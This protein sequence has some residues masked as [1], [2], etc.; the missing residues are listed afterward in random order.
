MN[1][2]RQKPH[3]K[4]PSPQ[5]LAELARREEM[6]KRIEMEKTQEETAIRIQCI[7]FALRTEPDSKKVI[8]IAEE[9]LKF[10]KKENGTDKA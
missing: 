3:V 6:L 9:Y 1:E 7:E 5:M 4:N 10:I 8:P 2:R